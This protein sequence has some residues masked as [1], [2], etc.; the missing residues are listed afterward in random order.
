MKLSIVVPVYNEEKTVEKLFSKVMEV[1]FS[2]KNVTPEILFIDDFST[3]SSRAI[4]KKLQA[5]E[6]VRVFF[7]DANK[8]KGAALRRGISEASGDYV[9]VQDADLEYNPQDFLELLEPVF[10]Y[11][12]DVVY[13]SRFTWSNHRKILNYWHYLGNAFL[14][15]ISNVFSGWNLTDMETCYKLIRKETLDQIHL[16]ENRFGIEPE[17]TAKLAKIKGL[18]VYEVPIFYHGRGY[19]EG[20]KIG[21]RDGFRAIYCILKYNLF[22]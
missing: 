21:I 10:K 8:G 16:C 1:D 9:I 3:D 15:K 22:N 20:K 19:D 6:G 17:I 13:G 18:N 7:Q 14:T 2:S 5:N 11:D 4:L 12:A